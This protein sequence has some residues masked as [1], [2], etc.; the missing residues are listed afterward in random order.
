MMNPIIE[1]S[2]SENVTFV[3][4]NT[5]VCIANG[6]RRTLLSDI[7]TVVFRV[8]PH[9]RDRCT[10]MANTSR[11]S[12]EIIKH[13]LSCIPIHVKD[14]SEFPLDRYKL[15]INVSNTDL[16]TRII[17]TKDFNVYDI[18]NKKYIP[19]SEVRSLFPPDLS[20]GDYIEFLRL[21][22]NISPEI[23]PKQLHLE[24]LFDIGTAKEEATF[25][26]VCTCSYGNTVDYVR[27]DSEL[28][29]IRKEWKDAGKT[30]DEIEFLSINWKLLEGKRIF[31]PNSFDFCLEGVGIYSASELMTSACSIIIKKLEFIRTQLT[32]RTLAVKVSETTLNNG[33]DITLDED[34]TIGKIVEYYLYSK[35]FE[36][37]KTLS[38]CAF[39]KLHPYDTTSLLRIAYRKPTDMGTMYADLDVCLKEASVILDKI[40]DASQIIP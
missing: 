37:T 2:N 17:T 22:G 5:P 31:V 19:E 24:C 38:Y 33:F 20:T 13:R 36:G 8:S 35:L 21:G 11:F 32:D 34:Y 16:V 10:I 23:P 18:E 7:P 40:R 26:V 39:K 29:R 9:E 28:E 27:Q 15:V 14:I 30:P 12:N 4:K 1:L 6:I 3:M 25:N